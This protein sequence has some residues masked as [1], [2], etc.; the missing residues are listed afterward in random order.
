MVIIVSGPDTCRVIG[1][2]AH[3]PHIP[4]I[5]SRT[6]LSG[7]AHTAE[8]HGFTGTL[9]DYV[10]HG[11]GQKPCGAV[12]EHRSAVAFRIVN[13]DIAVVIENPGVKDRLLI[14][15][16]VGDGRVGRGQLHVLDAVGDTAQ[17]HGLGVVVLAVLQFLLHGGDTHI[18]QVIDAQSRGNIGN[19]LYRHDIHGLLDTSPEGSPALIIL[20]VPVADRTSFSCL[21]YTSRCV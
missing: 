8:I 4:V 7:D 16:T 9:G 11:A 6:G 12:L 19:G 14:D 1:G 18:F 15:A 21:L 10:L 5:R 2:V 13:Q 20:T 17:N 3:K